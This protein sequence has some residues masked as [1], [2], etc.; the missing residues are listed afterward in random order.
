MSRSSAPVI[1]EFFEDC[2]DYVRSPHSGFSTGWTCPVMDH[3]AC[4]TRRQS[5]RTGPSR[6]MMRKPSSIVRAY[7]S[8]KPARPRTEGG[9]DERRCELCTGASTK[10]QGHECSRPPM[11]RFR[12]FPLR[13]TLAFAGRKC[14]RGPQP[15]SGPPCNP[16]RYRHGNASKRVYP[17]YPAPEE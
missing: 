17:V 8:R 4:S 15:W 5:R 1:A 6:V 12:P 11:T 16:R 9:R 13:R 3:I 2:C 14:R 7:S 10:S